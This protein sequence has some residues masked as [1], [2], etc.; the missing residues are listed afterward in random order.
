[1]YAFV[2]ADH[3]GNRFP[4]R[5]H[6]SILVF[7]S[8][9]P[10]LWLSKKQN[11]VKTSLIGSEFVAMKIAVELIECLCYKLRMFGI[12]LDGLTNIF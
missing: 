11:T 5:S 3:A 8:N 4:R 7:F 10:I 9:A 12:P 2:D 6:T 1:M